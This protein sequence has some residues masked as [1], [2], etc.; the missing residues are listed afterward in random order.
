[1]ITIHH[2]KTFSATFYSFLWFYV[3]VYSSETAALDD[4]TRP[5]CSSSFETRDVTEEERCAPSHATPTLIADGD[6]FLESR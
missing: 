2:F 6:A 3:F 1:M 4:S 5:P